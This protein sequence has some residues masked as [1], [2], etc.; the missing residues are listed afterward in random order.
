MPDKL[1]P[2]GLSLREFASG[3]RLGMH[4]ACSLHMEAAL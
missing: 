4:D 1:G 3:W 2:V